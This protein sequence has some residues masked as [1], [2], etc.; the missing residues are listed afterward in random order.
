MTTIIGI[1]ANVGEGIV[2]V[3]DREGITIDEKGEYKEKEDLKKIR[4]CLN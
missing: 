2:I 4:Y 1:E 3:G